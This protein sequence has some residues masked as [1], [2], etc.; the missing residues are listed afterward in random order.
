MT[1][2]E[3]MRVMSLGT[4]EHQRLQLARTVRVDQTHA[5]VNVVRTVGGEIAVGGARLERAVLERN[6]KRERERERM[7]CV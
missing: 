1:R 4:I 6:R 7:C 5:Q 2:A 3:S